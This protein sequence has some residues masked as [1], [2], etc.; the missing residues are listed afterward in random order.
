MDNSFH[1]K[2]KYW[3]DIHTR[4]SKHIKHFS[5]FIL[6]FTLNTLLKLCPLMV[7]LE[8]MKWLFDDWIFMKI[9]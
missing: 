9:I 6:S 1:F 2:F 4:C 5:S 7:V 3:Y 8:N